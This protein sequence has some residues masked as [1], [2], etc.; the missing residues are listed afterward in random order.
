M[1]SV[2]QD[3]SQRD[4]KEQ[5]AYCLGELVHRKKVGEDSNSMAQGHQTY[6]LHMPEID[7]DI[8][9]VQLLLSFKEQRLGW[10]QGNHVSS[11]WEWFITT[12][13]DLKEG[14]KLVNWYPQIKY[15][16]AEE[17]MKR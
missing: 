6:V 9:K 10:F 11:K 16:T 3:R 1:Q 15:T 4:G 5:S 8:E 17:Y 13:F 2:C 7:V 14:L 12:M